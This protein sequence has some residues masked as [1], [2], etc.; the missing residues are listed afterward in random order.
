MGIVLT[1]KNTILL[2]VNLLKTEFFHQY[3]AMFQKIQK[4][5]LECLNS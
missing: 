2:I 4:L 5:A 1:E 3:T